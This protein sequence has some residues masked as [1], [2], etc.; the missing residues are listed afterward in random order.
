MNL[1]AY[2]PVIVALL[3]SA[4]LWGFL[5]QR[6]KQNHE[7]LI[8]TEEKRAE[9]NDTLKS[10]VDQLNAKVDQL[11]EEKQELMEA[12]ADLRAELAAA[13]KTIEHLESMSRYSK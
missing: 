7:T 6:A 1:D 11:L 4:G 2:M 8:R 12:I 13:K 5:S 9:F 3:G 10:Q